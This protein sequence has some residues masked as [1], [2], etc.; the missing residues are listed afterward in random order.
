MKSF[1]LTNTQL[2]LIA[3]TAMTLDHIGRELLPQWPILTIIGRLAY[4]IF[5]YMIAEGCWHTKHRKQYF[6][7]VFGL[8]AVCQ[9][10]FYIAT[11][12]MYQ[13]I[14]ITFSLSIL[15]IYAID[16]CKQ[17]L[18][19]HSVTVPYISVL[20]ML[21]ELALVAFLCR[22]L[23]NKLDNDFWIDYGLIGVCIPVVL[24]LVTNKTYKLICLTIMLALMAYNMGGEQWYALI[25]VP[26][27]ALYNGKRGTARLKYL[28][29]IFY[30]SHLAIIYGIKM[31]LEQ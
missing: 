12:S 25:T 16:Y 9:I 24:Y 1:S 17:S 27:L 30:P 21:T 29:Y 28:F 13:N 15:T 5:A 18:D 7:T 31:L 22:F 14:L 11:G 10:V 4:P 2:K 3:I 26:L 20:L 23:P 8:G 19:N 6:L